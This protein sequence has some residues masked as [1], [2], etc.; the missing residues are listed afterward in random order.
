MVAQRFLITFQMEVEEWWLRSQPEWV[1]RGEQQVRTA[2]L[3]SGR[4][5]RK[6]D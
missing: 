4:R 1:S 6:T 5:R 2:L 3:S